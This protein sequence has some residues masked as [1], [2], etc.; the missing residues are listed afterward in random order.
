MHH[1]AAPSSSSMPRSRACARASCDLE[2]LTVLPICSAISS[3]VY[4]STSCSHTTARDVAL[5]RSN[6][7]SRSTRAGIVECAAPPPPP[8]PP[9]PLAFP[10]TPPRPPPLLP[11]TL[12]A[13]L[14]SPPLPPPPPPLPPAR[15]HPRPPPPPPNTSP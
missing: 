10:S 1:G 9:P 2:K 12:P 8:P 3:C 5:N 7:R 6:A 11:P 14:V 4:P 15:P 13:A